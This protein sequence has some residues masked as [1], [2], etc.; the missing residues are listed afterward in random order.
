MYFELPLMFLVIARRSTAC[1]A[2]GGRGRRARRARLARRDV[3]GLP[4]L[5]PSYL[6]AFL[7]LFGNAFSA[8]VIVDVL[9]GWNVRLVALP[10]IGAG[11]LGVGCCS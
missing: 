10:L 2:S 11:A 7:L 9:M 4:V 1:V 3:V 5:L 8:Y 6:G